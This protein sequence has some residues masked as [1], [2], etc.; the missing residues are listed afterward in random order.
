MLLH[1][2]LYI[3]FC[4]ACFHIAIAAALG[5][6]AGLPQ[7]AQYST[8]GGAAAGAAL[9]V[10]NVLQ[11]MHPYYNVTVSGSYVD[12]RVAASHGRVEQR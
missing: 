3:Q 9:S 8:R 2:L 1:I 4:W 10:H 6:A 11:F 12:R 5:G 7:L